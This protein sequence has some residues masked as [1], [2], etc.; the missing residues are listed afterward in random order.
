VFLFVVLAALARPSNRCRTKKKHKIQ[1]LGIGP[2]LFVER[3]V[4]LW[5]T[6]GRGAGDFS[7]R[8]EGW[9]LEA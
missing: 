3:G 2:L 8:E 6:E 9:A 1:G 4:E 5:K 7:F